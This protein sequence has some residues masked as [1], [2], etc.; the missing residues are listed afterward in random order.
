MKS[1]FIALENQKVNEDI[2]NLLISYRGSGISVVAC[3]PE[4]LIGVIK[5]SAIFSDA[6]FISGEFLNDTENREAYLE[7]FGEEFAS[8]DQNGKISGLFAI[9]K[10]TPAIVLPNDIS[11]AKSLY[12]TY[13]YNRKDNESSACN[14]SIFVSSTDIKRIEQTLE[15][16]EKSKEIEIKILPNKLFT[17]ISVTALGIDQ[18]TAEQSLKNRM[19]EIRLLLGDDVF[20]STTS[21][22]ENEVVGLLI[23]KNL[24]IASAESCTG[25]LLSKLITAVPNS[26]SIFELGITSY[27]NRIKQ[28]A[29]NVPKNILNDYGAV[30]KQTAAYMALGVKKLSSADIG[31]AITGVAGPASSE[32]KSVGTVYIALTNGEHFWVRGLCL[33]PFSSREDIRNAA[34][35]TAFDLVR[36]Y[37]ECLPTVLPEFSTNLESLTTLY[38]QPH[39]INSSLLFMKSTLENYLVEQELEEQAESEALL[40][41][42][43]I[44]SVS[45]PLENLQKKVLRQNKRRFKIKFNLPKFNFSFK[46]YIEQL[47]TTNDLKGFMIGTLS[48]VSALII[49]SALILVSFLSVNLF[50]EDYS[51]QKQ[52]KEIQSKWSGRDIISTSGEYFDYLALNE[53][54]P[55]ISGWLSISG[56]KIN[57]PVC[58]S[59]EPDYYKTKNINNKTSNYGALY[60]DS[61]T[62][63]VEKKLNTV[64]HGNNLNN[65]TMFSELTNYRDP[66]FANSTRHINFSTK[67]SMASYEVFA[68][69]MV[70]ESTGENDIDFFDYRKNDFSSVFEFTRWLSDIR[71]R[72]IYNSDLLINY[73]DEILTLVTDTEDF[74]SAKIVVF[75][76]K[77]SSEYLTGS[78]L[79]VNPSPKMPD[80]WYKLN[81]LEN[82]YDSKNDLLL[83]TN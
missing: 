22:I 68:V 58:S 78:T 53:I 77:L 8:Y 28:Y 73:G 31:V 45:T 29:L 3:A 15:S 5:K 24:K 48:K 21:H 4:K 43:K 47:L 6:V 61:T 62:N 51:E 19:E 50:S 66:K 2:L 9:I 80:I 54:N 11:K 34:A 76:R 55:D 36:R 60:F 32:G 10:G 46:D 71:L 69:V 56:T 67:K 25:G 72:S 13:F 83:G 18:D 63:L 16:L 33:S 70:N 37:I 49:I 59:G 79:R 12:F 39:Y 35:F 20:S 27:S 82:P 40:S 64:I 42:F 26:S 81:S 65:D 17:E 75:A 7:L 1:T 30:S 14:A 57:Y 23:E 38:E 74:N 41:Q 52:L 44:S